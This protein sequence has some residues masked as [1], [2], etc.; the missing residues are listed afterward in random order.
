MQENKSEGMKARNLLE[1]GGREA[2]RRTRWD[3]S[4]AVRQMGEILVKWAT[5][6]SHLA[7]VS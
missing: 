1:F 4:V 2:T 5:Q 3:Q 6:V 7:V